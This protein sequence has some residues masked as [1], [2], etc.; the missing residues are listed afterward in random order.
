[1]GEAQEKIVE[2]AT[3]DAVG[4][5][6]GE[7]VLVGVRRR[8]G[9]RAVLMGY[10]GALAVLIGS[11]VLTLEVLGWNEGLSAVVSLAG[12]GLYYFVMW[13]LRH[14]IDHSIHFTITR[15]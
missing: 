6:S 15:K 2:V 5:A 10:V 14:R 1:M 13:L 9:G 8:V 3:P 4:Y 7:E 12:V 11:L